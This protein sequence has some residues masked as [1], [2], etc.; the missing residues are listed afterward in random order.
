MTDGLDGGRS[1]GAVRSATRSDPSI[2]RWVD[3]KKEIIDKKRKR[4]SFLTDID[5]HTA[6]ECGRV[7]V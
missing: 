5:L 3:K 2:S 1:K 6:R 7:C 4:P